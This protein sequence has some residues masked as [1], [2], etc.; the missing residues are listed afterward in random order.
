MKQ[1]NE[2]STRVQGLEERQ[3][4]EQLEREHE[5]TLRELTRRVGRLEGSKR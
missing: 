5:E 1:K 3:R 4:R 2:R